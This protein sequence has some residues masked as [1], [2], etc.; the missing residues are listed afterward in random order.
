MLLAI[1]VIFTAL[2]A[3]EVQI[4]ASQDNRIINPMLGLVLTLLG[5]SVIFRGGGPETRPLHI[6]HMV[7]YF[8][9]LLYVRAM[10]D[11]IFRFFFNL[12]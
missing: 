4:D 11:F 10:L 5:S 9:C 3:L 2:M 7:M 6:V 8:A 1:V 12:Q